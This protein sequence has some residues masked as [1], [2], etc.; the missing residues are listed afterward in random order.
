[1]RFD[2]V[3]PKDSTISDWGIRT[4]TDLIIA[5]A[6]SL[7]ASKAILKL[8]ETS[9]DANLY[10]LAWD[11]TMSSTR[12]FRVFCPPTGD[13]E[14]VK[15]TGISQ[16]AWHS[17]FI[18]MEGENQESVFQ[19]VVKGSRRILKEIEASGGYCLS[20]KRQGFTFD[21]RI[22]E[23]GEVELIELNALIRRSNWVR[24]LFV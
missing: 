9:E 16:Y 23:S 10:F 22:P 12:E 18:F 19:A 13:P 14:E 11:P 21:V 3:S 8:L 1:V 15:I 20:L 2:S 17:A 4:P 24:K 6:T 5:L 7:R